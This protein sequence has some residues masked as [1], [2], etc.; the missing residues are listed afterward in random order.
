SL[1]VSGNARLRRLSKMVCNVDSLVHGRIMLIEDLAASVLLVLVDVD[2][3]PD[4]DFFAK[5]RLQRFLGRLEKR[6]LN[7][8][9]AQNRVDR[10]LPV[11]VGVYERHIQVLKISLRVPAGV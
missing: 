4:Q 8:L 1:K 3:G 7:G 9:I 6:I 5:E 10:A 11:V 2:Q